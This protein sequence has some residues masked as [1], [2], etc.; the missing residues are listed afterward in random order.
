MGTVFLFIGMEF[1]FVEFVEGVQDD[2][3]NGDGYQVPGAIRKVF[4]FDENTGFDV[5][6]DQ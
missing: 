4:V 1:L 6:N 3:E 5:E 2:E